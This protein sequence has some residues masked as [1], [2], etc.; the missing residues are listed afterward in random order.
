MGERGAK[1]KGALAQCEFNFFVFFFVLGEI[2]S[3]YSN[4]KYGKK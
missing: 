4:F 1:G 3:L 2:L